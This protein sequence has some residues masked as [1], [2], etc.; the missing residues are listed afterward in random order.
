MFSILKKQKIWKKQFQDQICS[1][2][3]SFNPSVA[4]LIC[5]NGWIY[6]IYDLSVLYP[7][8]KIDKRLKI[9]DNL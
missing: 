1:L 9:A 7:L 2:N 4:F 5:K 3:I 8:E 6:F